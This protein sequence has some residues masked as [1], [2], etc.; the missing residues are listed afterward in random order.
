MKINKLVSVIALS[1]S[2]ILMSTS[3]EALTS[4]TDLILTS[5]TINVAQDSSG[6]NAYRFDSTSGTWNLTGGVLQ[7]GD[8]L[9]G[10]ADYDSINGITIGGATSYTGLTAVFATMIDSITLVGGVVAPLGQLANFTFTSAATSAWDAIFGLTAN[11]IG[12]QTLLN[13]TMI[14]YLQDTNNS[15]STPFNNVATTISAATAS[16]QTMWAQVGFGTGSDHFWSATNAPLNISNIANANIGE[17]VGNYKFGLDVL[18]NLTGL[19]FVAVNSGFDYMFYNGAGQIYRPGTDN[20][21]GVEDDIKT[22][23]KV[24]NVPEPN[25]IGLMFMGGL[26]FV[27]S[28]LRRRKSI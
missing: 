27:F 25:S 5:P 10:V 15:F 1:T 4:F 19:D 23:F 26:I 14:A 2:S 9:A 12:G 3:S 28:S 17:N 6:E 22:T 16:S 8:I 7:V 21:F 24:N 20:A 18:Q 11:Q 13:G